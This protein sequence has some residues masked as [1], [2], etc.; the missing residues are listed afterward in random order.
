[1]GRIR[2]WI[3]NFVLV[4]EDP[5]PNPDTKLG[6]KWDPDPKKIIS[7]PQH[8]DLNYLISFIKCAHISFRKSKHIHSFRERFRLKK[9]EKSDQDKKSLRSATLHS[10]EQAKLQKMFFSY[11]IRWQK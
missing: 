7:D 3:L 6:R 2:D 4:K 11:L 9:Y 8:C 10:T 1:L 5:D